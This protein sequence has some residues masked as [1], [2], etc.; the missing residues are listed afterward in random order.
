MAGKQP[1]W[2]YSLKRRASMRKAQKV[3]KKMVELGR[4]E[5]LKRYGKRK[6]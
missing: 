3:H 6:K 1:E 2:V 4:E 5:Y